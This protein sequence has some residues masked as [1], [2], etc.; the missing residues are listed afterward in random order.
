MSLS[1]LNFFK[2]SNLKLYHILHTR[3]GCCVFQFNSPIELLFLE[4]LIMDSGYSVLSIDNDS[5]V[6]DYP[7]ER[8][9][10][11]SN[12]FKTSNRIK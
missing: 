11:L 2:E 10:K 4:S 9:E 3:D 7:L 12:R 6:T 1:N 8:W 5:A